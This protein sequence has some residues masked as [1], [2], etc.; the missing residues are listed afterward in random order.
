MEVE[1]HNYLFG[2]FYCSNEK[3]RS[4]HVLNVVYGSRLDAT[5]I[6][7]YTLTLNPSNKIYHFKI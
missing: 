5:E 1:I 3:Y 6:L 2:L 7:T 4:I